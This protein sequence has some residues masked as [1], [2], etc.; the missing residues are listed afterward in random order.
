[1]GGVW[2]GAGGFFERDFADVEGTLDVLVAFE[3]VFDGEEL[4]A[5]VAAAVV[6]GVETGFGGFLLHGFGG[7]FEGDVDAD[8]GFLALEDADEVAD[9]R[10]ADVVAAFDGEDDLFGFAG[11]V[12]VE[13]EATVDASVC[14]LLDAFGGA[15]SAEA[16]RPGLEL[17]FV[18][19]GEL[20]GSGYVGRFADDFVGL[21]N[22]VGE[23]VVEARLDEADGEVGDVDADPAAVE[24]LRDLDGGAAAA[25]G[26]EDYVA[27]V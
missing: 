23:G 24:F 10:D 2:A 12:V 6:R 11:A 26:I 17:K 8:L 18:L 22:V 13:V 3:E 19:F 20:R 9:F 16:E 7:F 15:G 27:F 4:E 21:A 14:A 1:M 5:G 25:E